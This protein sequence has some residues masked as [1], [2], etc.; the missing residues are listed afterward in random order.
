MSTISTSRPSHSSILIYSDITKVS[1]YCHVYDLKQQLYL[2]LFIYIYAL[3]S[4]KI[5]Y[6][7]FNG[8]AVV[9]IKQKAKYRLHMAYSLL[10]YILQRRP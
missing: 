9:T 7:H 4:Y 6:M 3:Y 5:L 8:S 1:L 2:Y 10:F